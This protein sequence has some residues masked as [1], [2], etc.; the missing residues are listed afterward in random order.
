M[1]TKIIIT[2]FALLV[3][4][5]LV[6]LGIKYFSSDDDEKNVHAQVVTPITQDDS[7]SNVSEDGE[8]SDSEIQTSFVP[9]LPTETL[10]STL[11][12]D[13]DGDAFDDQIVIVRKSGSSNLVIIVGLYNS[14]TNTYERSA[15]IPTEISRIRTF[16]Y[17]G[18][19]MIGNHRIALVYQGIKSDGDQVLNMYLCRRRRGVAE[20]TNIGSFTSDG[21]IFIQQAERSEAYEL[22]QA[23][24]QSYT[25][26]VYSSD[27]DAKSSDGITQVQTEYSWNS[28]SQSYVQT[29]RLEITGNSLAA[30]EL[31]RIQNGNVETFAQFLNGLW[32][33]TSNESLT[34]LYI[35]FDY[36]AKEIIL[37][38]DD[39]EGVY[40]WEESSLRRSG[41][42][43]STVNS[44]ISSMKRRF[45]IMLTGVNEVYIHV[46]DDVGNMPVKESNQWDGTY[47]K[48]A[49]QSVFGDDN[50][51]SVSDE[52]EK[53]LVAQKTWTDNAGNI[54]TFE[55]NGYKF[56]TT[57]TEENGIYVIETV[58]STPVIQFRSNENN[59]FLKNAYSM[60]FKTEEITVPA[61]RRN[62]KPTVET[63]VYKDEI[64]LS[65]IRIAPDSVFAAEGNTITLRI[66]S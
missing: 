14:E 24:G 46:R 56:Q 4:G 17:N 57:D 5:L 65:P 49:F 8:L 44:I 43:L 54:Y 53:V 12:I 45:D 26:W 18:I 36:D 21:T 22:S 50:A 34:P 41:I 16:S 25:V 20:I 64:I 40:F 63:R 35:H 31:S 42:Y 66:N 30:K 15:E 58:G 1:K 19:D 51:V 23:Q 48:M 6:F 52:Y 61:K 32:Y 59:S 33:K 3:A 11:S 27:K 9:L 62:Q 10:M 47:K 2:V 39:T 28:E 29:R 38:S 7:E 60:H 37:L 13:F 55:N